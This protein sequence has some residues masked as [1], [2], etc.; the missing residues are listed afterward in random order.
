M[1]YVYF[2]FLMQKDSFFNSLYACSLEI[3]EYSHNTHN[4]L[5]EFPWVLSALELTVYDF[6][7]VIEI[8]IRSDDQL[9]RYIIKHLS[10]VCF[11]SIHNF[12]YLMFFFHF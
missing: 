1:S 12:G 8:T 2:Q 6:V 5:R 3:V 7:K 9:P 4:S 11:P 10:W